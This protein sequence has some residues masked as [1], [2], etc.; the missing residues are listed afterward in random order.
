MLIGVQSD[1]YIKEN[2]WEK[3]A[4]V[5]FRKRIGKPISMPASGNFRRDFTFYQPPPSS[6]MNLATNIIS[7]TPKQNKPAN[8]NLVE[9]VVDGL[10]KHEE[11]EPP[12][13]MAP[14]PQPPQG[15]DAPDLY[16]SAPAHPVEP[17]PIYP[18][19][20]GRPVNPNLAFPA[21][22]YP[23]PPDTYR[24]GALEEP[25]PDLYGSAPARQAEPPPIYPVNRGRPVNPLYGFPAGGYPPPPDTYREGALGEPPPDLYGSAPARQAVPPPIYPV[26]RGR[27]VNPL[28]AFPAGGYPAPPDTYRDG[29]LGA[30]ASQQAQR[31]AL[32]APASQQAQRLAQRIQSYRPPQTLALPS[33]PIPV[34]ITRATGTTGYYPSSV[35]YMTPG[36]IKASTVARA[37]RG[38]MITQTSQTGP[39]GFPTTPSA[40]TEF[41]TGGYRGSKPAIFG[42]NNPT[43][44]DILAEMRGDR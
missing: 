25:P 31:L 29:A 43:F 9:Q 7:I 27:P 19:N 39:F 21:G 41:P 23:P 35:L 42:P 17:P 30:A 32:E 8:A 24:E 4:P 1:K 15:D 14:P 22:G 5:D 12:P 16:G 40:K 3:T 37:Y 2:C 38:G 10:M 28:Y 6:L 20:R 34:Q 13:P 26:N 11:A 33:T 44:N 18:V 36:Q